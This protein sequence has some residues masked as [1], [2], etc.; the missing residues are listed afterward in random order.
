MYPA[1]LPVVLHQ[2][3]LIPDHTHFTADKKFWYGYCTAAVMR[4]LRTLCL[5]LLLSLQALPLAAQPGGDDPDALL[6]VR[7]DNVN[8]TSTRLWTND[9]LRYRYNQMRYYVTTILPYL[10]EATALFHE[11][12]EKMQDPGLGKKERK[13][14][15]ET[16]E[17]LVRTR[18]EEKIRMLNTTQGVL[19]VKL[20]ARQTGLN[21]YGILADFKSP[22]AAMKWQAWARFN[23]FNLNR[24]YHPEEEKDLESIMEG[25]GYPLPGYYKQQS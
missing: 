24:K 21:L 19:L 2:S 4:S 16:R 1:Q 9:T 15:I 23:G 13:A 8:V 5:S 7:L 25:L 14:F 20:I 18:F 22:I 17:E 6:M 10:N 3:L 11:I 12:D